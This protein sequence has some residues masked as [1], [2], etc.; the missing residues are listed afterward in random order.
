MPELI[1]EFDYILFLYF[2][3]KYSNVSYVYFINL[4]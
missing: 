4:I 3:N 2:L 1:T